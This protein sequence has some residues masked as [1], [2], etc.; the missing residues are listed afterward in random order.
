MRDGSID[1]LILHGAILAF[2]LAM[3]KLFP[4]L[5]TALQGVYFVL[6][7][8]GFLTFM[9]DVDPWFILGIVVFGL[10]LVLWRADA[11]IR[12]AMETK[13]E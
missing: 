8:V 7:P 9:D 3:W 6:M 10:V 5:K 1:I 2:N 4:R 13:P 11:E 12:K